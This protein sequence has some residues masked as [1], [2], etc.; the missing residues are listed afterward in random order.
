MLKGENCFL[1]ALE[2][3]DLDLFYKWEN[4]PEIW[5]MSNTLTPFSRKVLREYLAQAH[6]DIYASKQL[7]LVICTTEGNAVGAVDLFDFDPHN[8]RAGIGILI[9]E[10]MHR[11]RGIATEV[12]KLMK[13]YCAEKLNLHQ[14]YCNISASNTKSIK[15]FEHCNFKSCGVKKD[16]MRKPKG[17][18]DELMFQCLL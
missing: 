1:R 14:L 13:V 9:A 10:E 16:W 18:E 2:P 15:L 7:R 3:E 11:R 12:I 6:L 5:P 8:L 17:Y 4:N